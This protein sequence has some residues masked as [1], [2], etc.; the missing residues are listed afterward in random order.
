MCAEVHYGSRFHTLL[1]VFEVFAQGSGDRRVGDDVGRLR[2]GEGKPDGGHRGDERQ[3]EQNQA[4]PP[5]SPQM[6]DPGLASFTVLAYSGRST[7]R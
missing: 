1:Q 6:P 2:G 4:N 3:D 5:A 7:G